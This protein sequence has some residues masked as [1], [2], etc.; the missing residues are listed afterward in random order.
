MQR[1]CTPSLLRPHQ[2]VVNINRPLCTLSISYSATTVLLVRYNK[3]LNV[4]VDARRHNVSIAHKGIVG[5]RAPPVF[6][7]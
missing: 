7:I 4:R 2:S 5:L 1:M 3:L 6:S